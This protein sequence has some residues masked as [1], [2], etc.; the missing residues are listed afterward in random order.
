MNGVS[1]L[2]CTY[3]GAARLPETFRYVAAQ[4]VPDH[5]PWE[6]LLVSNASTDDTIATAHRLGRELGLPVPL[7]VLDEPKAGKENALIRGLNEAAYEFVCIVD[8]DNWVAPDYVA[9]VYEVMSAHPEIGI[10]GAHAEG[11]YEVPPPKWFEEFRAVY[12]IG[13]QNGG[14]N[15]PLPADSG[16]LY[17]AGSVVRQSAWRKLL[18][19]GFHFTTSTKRGKIIVSGEDVELGDA[20]RLAGYKLWYD[21]RLRLQH[22]MYKERLTWQYLM[23]IGQGTASSQLTSVVYYFIFRHPHLTESRFRRL[24]AK[25]LLWLATQI[26][27]QP[28]NLVNA[29]L[30][31]D[32]EELTSNFETMRL[33]YNFKASVAQREEAV[34]VFR[35]VRTLQQRLA[36]AAG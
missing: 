36:E 7:R 32:Q 11:A 12:A 22:F 4:Q 5:L 26:A 13:P 23:R 17:G 30:R 33:L 10:L 20:L 8:D 3:N 27:R 9:K 18:A 2:I 35:I 31:P 1:I 14:Q 6:V 16:Y 21:D 25:R 29:L 34:Q 19:H 15:G 28:A 24:Y